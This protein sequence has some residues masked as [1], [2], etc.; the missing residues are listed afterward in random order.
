[1]MGRR[2]TFIHQWSKIINP[3]ATERHSNVKKQDYRKAVETIEIVEIVGVDP[4]PTDTDDAPVGTTK[5]VHPDG[6]I[7]YAH[8]SMIGAYKSGG[9][10]EE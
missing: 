6:R 4:I 8:Q 1:M 9:F 10:R 5:L 2:Q 3:A 7:A